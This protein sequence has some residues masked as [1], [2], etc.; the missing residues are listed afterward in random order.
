MA[1]YDLANRLARQ[2]KDSE[3]YTAYKEIRQQITDDSKTR[4][5]LLDYQRE[6]IKIQAKQ[7]SGQEVTEEE[8]GKFSNLRN[9]IELNKNIK[10]YLD[11]E[12][13][14]STMLSD[15]QQILFADLELGLPDDEEKPS[16]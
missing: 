1:V 12:Y 9:I 16:E 5:M 8:K 13:R 6:Q 3:E 2:I 14:V 4:E 7:L 11:A 10:R 15:I